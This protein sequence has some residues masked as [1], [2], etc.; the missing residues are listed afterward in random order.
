MVTRRLELTEVQKGIFFDC[1]IDDPLSYNITASIMLEGVNEARLEQALNLV[2]EEQEAL[3]CSLDV[4][5]EMPLLV[6]H[7][8]INIQLTKLDFSAEPELQEERVKHQ[9]EQ[10][11]SRVF[12][13]TAA[14]LFHTSLI[15]LSDKKHIF[16]ISIHHIISDGLSLEVLKQKLME[17]DH[18]LARKEPIEIQP[19]T[20]FTDFMS[21]E[22]TKL[23]QG[24]YDK[25]REYWA[26]KMVGAE[27]LALP[28]DFIRHQVHGVGKEK[29]FEIS[30]NLLQQIHK[31]AREQEVTTFMFVLAAFGVLLNRYTQQEDVVF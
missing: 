21:Q 7:K 20:G 14:P 16:L 18:K 19:N 17:Y 5:D 31:Q 25:E 13:L 27:P 1:Q 15:K 2:I 23:A 26:K 22:N 8:R 10:E 3:R 28:N 30:S 9:V 12:D 24:G 4:S 29:R 6:V 11:L